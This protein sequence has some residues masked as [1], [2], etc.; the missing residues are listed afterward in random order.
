[1]NTLPESGEPQP[2]RRWLT[3]SRQSVCFGRGIRVLVGSIGRVQWSAALA[4]PLGIVALVLISVVSA[5]LDGS[6]AFASSGIRWDSDGLL[7]LAVLWSFGLAI[8]ALLA[9]LLFTIPRRRSSREDDSESSLRSSQS[10]P[11]STHPLTLTLGGV[12]MAIP[13][14]VTPAFNAEPTRR[15]SVLESFGGA[16]RVLFLWSMILMTLGVLT[17]GCLFADSQALQTVDAVESA[18]WIASVDRPWIAAGWIFCLQGFWQLLPIPQSIGRV[19]WSSAIGLF[20]S[21]GDDSGA[22]TREIAST[23][24]RVVRWWIAGFSL[25]TFALGFA[26]ISTAGIDPQAGGRAFPAYTGVVLLALW[27]LLS[28]Q[29]EDLFASQLTL[30]DNGETGIMKSRIGIA[31]MWQRW[32][33][34][35]QDRRRTQKLRE[36]AVRE[37]AEASDAARVDDILK[38]LHVDGPASLNDEERAILSRVSEAIRRERQRDGR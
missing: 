7:P 19:G 26:A 27:L 34:T 5:S 32:Q 16:S 30:A 18:P 36:T 8:Q 28:I 14:L 15:E 3:N 23:A 24:T 17:M 21:G 20:A 9:Q 11:T 38:R 35:R 6:S 29:N 13:D 10:A 25:L 31:T 12:W 33:S 37:R 1:L 2:R 4:V 22:S